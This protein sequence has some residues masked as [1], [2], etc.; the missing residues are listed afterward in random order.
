MKLALIRRTKGGL[1]YNFCFIHHA[2]INPSAIKF[3]IPLEQGVAT[4]CS[5]NQVLI[6]QFLPKKQRVAII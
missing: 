4:P 3:F 6:D 1:R 2:G 5:R